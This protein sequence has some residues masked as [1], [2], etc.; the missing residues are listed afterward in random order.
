MGNGLGK[1][2]ATVF[3][4]LNHLRTKSHLIHL[5]TQFIRAVKS[6]HLGYKI[7]SVNAV[8]G[9]LYCFF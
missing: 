3:E 2:Q 5:E 6:F 1:L 8:L 7:Q 4:G 9:K